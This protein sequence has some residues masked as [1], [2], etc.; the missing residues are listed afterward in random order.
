MQQDDSKLPSDVELKAGTT[1]KLPISEDFGKARQSNL[2]ARAG[3]KLTATLT[4]DLTRKLKWQTPSCTK[5]QGP[6]GRS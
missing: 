3:R 1:Y 4:I 6:S 5:F 2:A